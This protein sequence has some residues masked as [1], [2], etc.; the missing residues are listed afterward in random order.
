MPK[1]Y[2]PVQR[3]VRDLLTGSIL[4][5]AANAQEARR[6]AALMCD[7]GS[8]DPDLKWCAELD[9]DDDDGRLHV[10][11][12]GIE[13]V[14]LADAEPRRP[15]PEQS[16]DEREA[17]AY[18]DRHCAECGADLVGNDPCAPDCTTNNREPSE[19]EAD[20]GDYCG[21]CGNPGTGDATGC[22]ADCPHPRKES[23]LTVFALGGDVFPGLAR[24]LT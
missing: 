18:A 12:E 21:Q 9:S 2:V 5:D 8:L 20:D 13:D 14:A 15:E 1:Y 3:V 4:V 16:P 6:K 19:E 23:L 24:D 7:Y 11:P 10:V 17:Q 22:T